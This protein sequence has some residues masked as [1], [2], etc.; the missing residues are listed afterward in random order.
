MMSLKY[1]LAA[2]AIVSSWA[3][4]RAS[5]AQPAPA[6][7]P[8]RDTMFFVANGAAVTPFGGQVDVLGGEG[9]VIGGVVKDKPYSADSVTESTQMLADGNRIVNR[10][11]ARVYRDS[12]GRTRREQTLNGLGVWQTANE[13]LTMVTI[14]DPVADVSFFLDPQRRT[15][16]KLQP[17]RLALDGNATW[18]RAVPAPP[19]GEPGPAAVAGRRVLVENGVVT[20]DVLVGRPPDAT[21]GE[22]PVPF[23]LPPPPP[24]PGVATRGAVAGGGPQ[25]AVV[26]RAFGPVAM[27]AFGFSGAQ[28]ASEDL[29]EQ[30]LEGVLTHGTRETQT[31]PAG[32]IGNE[33]AIDIV[34]E[35]WYSNEIE[36]VVLRRN[37]DPRFGETTYRLANLVRSEPAP[38]LFA[39]PQGYEL[40]SEPAFAPPHVELRSFEPGV[41]QGANLGPPPVGPPGGRVERRVFLV[42]P[43]P[44][45]APK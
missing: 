19:P 12:Q 37:V 38:D 7:E 15:A 39:V 21:A 41:E 25:T 9:S 17:F 32:A 20:S 28:T 45:A 10:N 5:W 35:Q 13:P 34:A 29:G 44:A 3:L 4:P 16:R 2:G 18:T 30:V 8:Q 26:T 22:P 40:Q 24:G 1:A 11:E 14:N 43:D 42:Q 27:G 6:P 31:I 23:E 33:R 36:A